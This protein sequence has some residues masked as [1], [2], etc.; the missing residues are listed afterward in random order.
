MN[1]VCKKQTSFPSKRKFRTRSDVENQ[2][3]C[4]IVQH[5]ELVD[6]LTSG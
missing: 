4:G 1:M 6:E 3:M 5:G 2:D